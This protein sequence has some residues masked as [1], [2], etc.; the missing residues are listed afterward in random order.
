MAGC[1]L[2]LPNAD[3]SVTSARVNMF[4]NLTAQYLEKS[5][6]PNGFAA[7][8]FWDDSPQGGNRNGKLDPGDKVWSRL[9]IWIDANHDGIADPG[10]LHTLDSEGIASISLAYENDSY[11][12]QFG[13][14]FRYKGHLVAMAADDTVDRKIYDV[15]LTTH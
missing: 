9:R 2:V 12:D 6:P 14:A 1:W 13:N 7:M 5:H 11:V 15:Y 10:E 3:G 8:P 4:G